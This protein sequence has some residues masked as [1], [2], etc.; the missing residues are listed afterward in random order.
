LTDSI[1]ELRDRFG[2]PD[3][4]LLP[5]AAGA[6]LPFLE[7]LLP[8]K[9]NHHRLTTPI[10]CSPRNA[11]DIHKEMGCRRSIGIHWGTFTTL[12]HSKMTLS[13]LEMA[14]KE[15]GVSDLWAHD[16]SFVAADIGEWLE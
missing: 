10:H 7:S 8:F 16:A 6:V 15:T 14:R 2:S 5:I 3:L 1:E 13:D 12:T 9:F 4:A 11:V